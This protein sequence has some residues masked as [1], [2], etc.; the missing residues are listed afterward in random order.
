MLNHYK[1][2]SANSTSWQGHS[3]LNFHTSWDTLING[4]AAAH[5]SHAGQTTK[6]DK[7]LWQCGGGG[8]RKK[9][10]LGMTYYSIIYHGS[11]LHLI[12]A[13]WGITFWWLCLFAS[14][15]ELHGLFFPKILER[16]GPVHQ[17]AARDIYVCIFEKLF[18]K[19]KCLHRLNLIQ[20]VLHSVLHIMYILYKACCS[21]IASLIQFVFCCSCWFLVALIIADISFLSFCG[22]GDCS[23][24]YQLNSF[25]ATVCNTKF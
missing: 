13:W 8:S 10:T 2:Q 5:D 11:V 18:E 4:L 16:R 14:L 9:S 22:C 3:H 7:P 1:N 6:G 21:S 15:Q 17:G 20:F 19:K 23:V 25:S 24:F 12:S